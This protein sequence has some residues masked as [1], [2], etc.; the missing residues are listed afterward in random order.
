[1]NLL[2]PKQLRDRAYLDWLRTQPCLFTGER[3]V[4]P[5]HIG[6]AGKGLKIGDDQ[7]IPLAWRLHRLAHQTGE[8]SM[9]RTWAPDWL[10]RDS[11]RLYAQR[12]YREWRDD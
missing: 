9:T 2:K 10:L 6:T 7:A 1:M 8:I 12:M 3:E 11:L 5:A 4:E